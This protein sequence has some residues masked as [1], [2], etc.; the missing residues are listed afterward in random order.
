MSATLEGRIS[1]SFNAGAAGIRWARIATGND[2]FYATLEGNVALPVDGTPFG[3]WR[4][5]GASFDLNKVRLLPPVIPT[6]FYACGI[7]YT[8]HAHACSAEF[9]RPLESFLPS[10]PQI[11]YRAQS[12]IIA[13]GETIVLPADAPDNIQCEGELAVVIGK[14][15]RNVRARD[16]LDFVLGYTIGNDVSIRDWQ[17]TDRTFWRSKN[18]DTFKP[19]GPWIVTG[20]DVADMTTRV[21]VNGKVT[22]QF[23]TANMLFSVADYIEAITEYITLQPGDVIIMGTDGHSPRIAHGDT[24]EIAIEGIGALSNPVVRAEPVNRR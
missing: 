17:F 10:R 24:I 14:P 9:D 16:A 12:A 20:L 5:A 22:E 6:T 15:A 7:N 4:H 23:A 18:S 3:E 1:G 13:S 19:L 21:S 11:G 8:G 2:I